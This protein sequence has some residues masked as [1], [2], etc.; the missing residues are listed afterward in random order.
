MKTITMI[1]EKRIKEL[2]KLNSN[3]GK[4]LAYLLNE[5]KHRDGWG[6]VTMKEM[7]EWGKKTE[8][9]NE[10]QIDVC[11]FPEFRSWDFRYNDIFT[12][13]FSHGLHYVNVKDFNQL[14]RRIYQ[15]ERGIK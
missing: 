3:S 7:K 11:E 4:V 6:G 8:L 14:V 10:T 2:V 12:C 1:S 15:K 9:S 5:I 13:V